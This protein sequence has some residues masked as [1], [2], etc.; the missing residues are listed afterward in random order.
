MGNTKAKQFIEDLEHSKDVVI[1][2]PREELAK[3]VNKITHYNESNGYSVTDYYNLL[4]LLE[5]LGYI[6]IL[7]KN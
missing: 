2:I 3:F 7:K 6:E 5:K 4:N 1:V